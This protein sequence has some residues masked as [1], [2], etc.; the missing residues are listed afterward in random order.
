M[1]L[2]LKSLLLLQTFQV[3]KALVALQVLHRPPEQQHA[4][5]VPKFT[6]FLSSKLTIYSLL[7]LLLPLPP[8]LLF[9]PPPVPPQSLLLQVRNPIHSVDH[10][11][12]NK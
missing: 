9:P 3:L 5:V 6:P 4:Y 8:P 11:L 1:L 10:S 7:Q 12:A 2:P